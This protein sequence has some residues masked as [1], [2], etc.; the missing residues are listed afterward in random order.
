MI[1][2]QDFCCFGQGFSVSYCRRKRV[3]CE[4]TVVTP[5]PRILGEL[6]V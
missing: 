1:V 3:L 5:H 2:G 6:L 4:K